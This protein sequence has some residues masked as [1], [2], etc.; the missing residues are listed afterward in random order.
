MKVVRRILSVFCIIIL[1]TMTLVVVPV[2]AA[3]S[4]ELQKQQDELKKKQ[5]D[6]RESYDDA[7]SSANEI[8]A[9]QSKVKGKINETNSQL[10]TLL[11]NV[12][13]IKE[14]IG[15]KETEIA[16]TQKEYD[17][18][19][20]K[21]K[22]LY[23]AMCQRIK[24]MYEKG[25]RTYMDI[26]M[27][28]TSFSDLT[29]KAEYVEQLYEYDRLQLAEYVKAQQAAATE[30]ERL[31]EEKGELE[32][33]KDE[34]G[35]Q[36]GQLT[37]LL[38][39]YKNEYSDYE[40][41]VAA[42]KQEAAAYKRQLDQQTAAIAS[43]GNQ[44]KAKKAEEEAERKA[45]EEA[46]RKAAEEAARKAAEE[47]KQKELEEKAKEENN[48]ISENSNSE[49]QNSDNSNSENKDTKSQENKK[50]YQPAGS[51]S[52]GNVANYACQFVGNPYVFG[53]T[54]LTDGCD[55][56]GFVYSVYKA[57][58]ITV[59]RNSY[60]LAS[61]GRGVSYEEAQPGD[62]IVYPGHCAIYLGNDRIVHASSA[63]TGIKYG[64]ALYRSVTSI[65]RFL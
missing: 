7:K 44:I 54:S 60:A 18:A 22:T 24:Y 38:N 55:C 13:M 58:G 23:K 33:T 30:K 65:R 42:A 40:V 16:K 25:D 45:A 3:T 8:Q 29:T 19:V 37:A 21:E 61:A 41:Q 64:Y 52:P 20:D 43:L 14:E 5:Q 36:E 35:E 57:F 11:A 12:E 27:K 4:S 28:A 48:R 2:W 53:G 39:Q 9:Q 34:L 50:S 10:V 62:V 56:S 1:M 49:N 15:T 51:A 17:D 26:L 47:K 46:A 63:R 6:I 32:T 31:E 59:P